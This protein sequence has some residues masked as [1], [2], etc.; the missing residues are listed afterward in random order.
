[1]DGTS[2]PETLEGER[3]EFL[4]TFDEP[5]LV[6]NDQLFWVG[7]GIHDMNDTCL[8]GCETSNSGLMVRQGEVY[9]ESIVPNLGVVLGY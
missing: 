7:F 6:E 1:L 3:Y 4:A 5:L 9:D 2:N 8:T